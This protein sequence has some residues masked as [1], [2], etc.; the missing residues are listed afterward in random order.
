MRLPPPCRVPSRLPPLAPKAGALPV[1][2]A[3]LGRQRAGR[4][5]SAPG[6]ALRRDS[7][8]GSRGPWDGGTLDIS[9]ALGRRPRRTGARWRT[10]SLCV[11]EEE[12]IHETLPPAAPGGERGVWCEPIQLLRACEQQP[13]ARRGTG[14]S[15][16][17]ILWLFQGTPRTRARPMLRAPVACP[18]P[19]AFCGCSFC[20]WFVSH[21]D[22][23]FSQ[24][25]FFP[26]PLENTLLPLC[27]KTRCS[28]HFSKIHL[29][30]FTSGVYRRTQNMTSKFKI[31]TTRVSQLFATFLSEVHSLSFLF[32]L[33]WM[34]GDGGSKFSRTRSLGSP[35]PLAHCA[36]GRGWR[37]A[38]VSCGGICAQRRARQ[39]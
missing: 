14:R 13:P 1:G 22:R 11:R 19:P 37:Q 4:S 6:P 5:N 21:R 34:L 26:P 24:E 16:H 28:V 3:F 12:E 18:R 30:M 31:E 35:A 25:S 39:H 27:W 29:S 7:V 2:R 23:T 33:A 15:S 32:A 38:I 10:G 36:H 20:V 9:S 17:L 8:S